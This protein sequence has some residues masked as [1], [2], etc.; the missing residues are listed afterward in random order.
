MKDAVFWNIKAKFVPHRKY[1]SATEPSR[2]ML[3]QI[4]G[5]HGG[6]NGT[7]WLTRATNQSFNVISN[8]GREI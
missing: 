2:L 1:V 7:G 8:A 4:K 6:E 5:V 3:C